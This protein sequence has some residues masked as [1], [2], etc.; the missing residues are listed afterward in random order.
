MRAEKTGKVFFP[1]FSVISPCQPESEKK[2]EGARQG[3]FFG[4]LNR[5]SFHSLWEKGRLDWIEETK[6]KEN[7][8]RRMREAYSL[9]RFPGSPK[10]TANLPFCFRKQGW[11][12]KNS[13][14]FTPSRKFAIPFH[15]SHIVRVHSRDSLGGAD[16]NFCP[17]IQKC[18]AKSP[19][20]DLPK[21]IPPPTYFTTLI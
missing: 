16:I 5:S 9:T 21:N 6:N 1:F 7:S 20:I 13:G 8:P 15:L 3:T 11:A 17:S 18:F 2:G 19:A 10:A 4:E 14:K 12:K